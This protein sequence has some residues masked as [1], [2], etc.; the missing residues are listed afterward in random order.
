ML[1]TIRE[2]ALERFDELDDDEEL[3]RRHAAYYRALALSASL[4]TDREGDQHPEVVMPDMANLRLALS[5]ALERGEVEFGLELL[6]DL[7]QLWVLGFTAEGM[8]WYSA[9]LEHADAVPARLRARALRSYGSSVHFAGKFALAEQLWEQS[10]AEYEAL[11]DDHGMAVLLHRL[12]ISSLDVRGDPVRARELSERSLEIHQRLGND[13][14]ACQPLALLGALAL[15]VGDAERGVALLGESAERAGRVGWRWWRAGTLSM[16]ADVALSEG[17]AADAEKL[18]QEALTLA[19]K[20]GDRVG[21]SWYLSQYALLLARAG[22]CE[23]AGRLWGAVEAA[24]AFVPGGPWPRDLESVE[25]A[26]N[27]VRNGDFERGREAG[28]ALPLEEAA[29]SIA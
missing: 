3:R 11:G 9:F 1:E 5:W 14:G 20:L 26:L 22:K 27:D 13:K 16:L 2:F 12:S 23:E 24:N 19:S 28:A 15:Q 29:A 8:H 6:V 10:L 4:D 21:L 7:E 18:L 17:R 25:R